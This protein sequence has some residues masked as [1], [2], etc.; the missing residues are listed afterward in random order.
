MK[1]RTLGRSYPQAPYP[2]RP[3]AFDPENDLRFRDDWQL[4]LEAARAQDLKRLDELAE[5]VVT[6]ANKWRLWRVPTK[7]ILALTARVVVE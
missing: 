4:M 2:T 6:L 7:E 1:T 3:I 5:R